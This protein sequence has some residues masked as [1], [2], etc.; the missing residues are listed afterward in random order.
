MKNKYV[1]TAALLC[2]ITLIS[3]SIVKVAGRRYEKEDNYVVVTSFY[4]IYIA[5]L[6]VIDDTEHVTLENLTEPTTGCLHDYQL[7]TKDLKLL[8][9][10][11][12]LLVNGG[13]M[14]SFLDDVYTQKAKIL[15]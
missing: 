1:F 15:N 7:A 10:A 13:G 6:N 3:F 14:E 11:D 9:H 12:L 5:A 4:P 2:V 8:E